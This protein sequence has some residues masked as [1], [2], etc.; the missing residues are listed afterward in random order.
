MQC[1]LA[2]EYLTPL[3]SPA[4]LRQWRRLAEGSLGPEPMDCQRGYSR[5]SLRLQQTHC[6]HE[7]MGSFSRCSD[8][9]TIAHA[10]HA[11]PHARTTTGLP[12]QTTDSAK[13][14]VGMQESFRRVAAL[15][16]SSDASLELFGEQQM[17]PNQVQKLLLFEAHPELL[18]QTGP[19]VASYS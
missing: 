16:S 6:N 5:P 14:L 13:V 19:P 9:N 18:A 3:I 12:H 4:V 17:M 11:Q 7:S 1:H 10:L 8:S 2:S 15:S